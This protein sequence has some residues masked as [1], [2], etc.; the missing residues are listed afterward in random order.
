MS[1]MIPGTSFLS[2]FLSVSGYYESYWSF[3]LCKSKRNRVC[4][5][6]SVYGKRT[7]IP[8]SQ[9]LFS[10]SC[11]LSLLTAPF[12]F[13]L[14]SFLPFCKAL[15]PF[16]VMLRNET[17]CSI[18]FS[19]YYFYNQSAQTFICILYI[20][21]ETSPQ[22]SSKQQKARKSVISL[23]ANQTLNIVCHHAG[24]HIHA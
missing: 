11:R 2:F 14:C 1:C 16:T 18:Y 10:F 13:R 22:V 8:S 20:V 24:S 19:H 6:G 9:T 7:R 21:S 23:C 5:G 17:W 15:Y 3:Y 4:T 12:Y